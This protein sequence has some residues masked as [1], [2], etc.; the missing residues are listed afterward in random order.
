M[1]LDELL[2]DLAKSM[3]AGEITSDA[4]VLVMVR[5]RSV[6]FESPNAWLLAPITDIHVD[7]DEPS[8][9]A[10]YE[11]TGGQ[12]LS[13]DDLIGRAKGFPRE[14]VEYQVFASRV[15]TSTDGTRRVRFDTPVAAVAV[16]SGSYCLVEWYEGIGGE[17]QGVPSLHA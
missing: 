16:S 2:A 17:M 5:E 13:V 15:I 3:G 14:Y 1:T 8:V 12:G 6:P 4:A 11:D 9:D 7:L 10:F